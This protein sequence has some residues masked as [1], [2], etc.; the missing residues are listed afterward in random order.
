MPW[1]PLYQDAVDTRDLL[2]SFNDDRDVAFVVSDGRGKWIAR[3]KLASAPDARYCI[4]HLPSGPLPLFRGAQVPTGAVED[5]W[6]GWMESR[7]GADP[8]LPYFGAG[9]P[10]VIWWNVRTESVESTGGIG[11]SSLEWIGNHYRVIGVAAH[12]ATETWWKGLR[13]LVKQ[14]GA[15]RIP[16]EGPVD[17]V[18]AEIWALPGALSRIE[19]GAPRDANPRPLSGRAGAAEQGDEADER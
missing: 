18:G 17:G 7:A 10:G 16:R 5:P 11:L 13:K 3:R 2:A 9:H 14:K 6:S 4:W 12:P 19:A 1:L 15:R 8:T